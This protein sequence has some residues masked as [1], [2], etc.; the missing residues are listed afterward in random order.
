MRGKI[1]HARRFHDA[2]RANNKAAPCRGRLAARRSGVEDYGAQVL[3][4]VRTPNF[5]NAA[6][7]ATAF[8]V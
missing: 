4:G 8:V 6:L 5:A 2:A 3:H 1:P 7:I